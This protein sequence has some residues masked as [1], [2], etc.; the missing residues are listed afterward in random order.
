MAYWG[1]ALA[2]G[3]NINQE[4][5][6]ENEKLTYEYSRKALSLLSYASPFE[7]AYIQA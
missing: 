1:M 5:T 4:I 6:P 3:Q 7:K 2:L